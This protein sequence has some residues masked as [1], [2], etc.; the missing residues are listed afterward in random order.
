M[1]K[2]GT[3]VSYGGDGR[4]ALAVV[5]LCAAAAIAYLARRCHHPVRLARPGTA[6]AAILV[7]TWVLAIATFFTAVAVY[8]QQE[9]Q[10]KLLTAAPTNPITAVTVTAA[11]AIFV[12]IFIMGTTR[13]L[14][15]KTSLVSAA[16]GAMVAP[17]I[18]EFPFDLA[19]A[20]R[21]YPPIPPYPALYRAMFFLPFFV[22][23]V[24]ILGLLTLS[25]MVRLSKNT[26]LS[27]ASMF[28]VFALWA[29]VGF[30][31]PSTPIAI[32]LNVASKL[33]AFLA[34]LTMFLPIDHKRAEAVTR[35]D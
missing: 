34:T 14:T 1:T 7:I 24:T 15:I 2:Y 30:Q 29:M 27:I 19:I 20:G 8:V 35:R 33:L 32:T 28:V 26:F 4:I 17:T 13:N 25:P 5:F 10:Q 12:A 31:Y 11:L 18:F 9:R 23:Q 21:L 3:W 16:V 22:V 6:A